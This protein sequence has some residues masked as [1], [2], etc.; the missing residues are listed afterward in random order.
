MVDK[1]SKSYDVTGMSC[2][3]C[4]ARV[5]KAVSAI[6]GVVSC[7]VNLLTNSMTVDGSADENA[8]IDAVVRAGYGASLKA[9]P[10]DLSS[11][12]YNNEEK[13]RIDPIFTRLISSVFLL[14]ILM[15]LSMGHMLSLPLPNFIES[16]PI[17]NVALQLILSATVMA[18]N[19][20]FFVNGTKG[21]I[22]RAPNMDTLVSLGSAAAFIY[23]TAQ[24]CRMIN[25]SSGLLHSLYFESA[26]MIPT[27]ITVGKLL[28]SR[29]KGKTTSALKGL[30]DLSPKTATVI[31]DGKEVRIKAEE[32]NAGDIFAVRPGESFPADGVVIKGESAVN[33]SMLTG[34]SIPV[35]K[36]EGDEVSGAT[37]N[38]SGY[39]ECRATK[40]GSDTILSK[41]IKTV[42]DAAAT[43]APIARTA[44][45]VAGVFVPAVMAIA[46]VTAAT[47]FILGE[48]VGVAL[49]RAISVLVISCPCALGLAT[50]VAIMVGSGVGAKNGILFKT[51][52]ALEITGKAK[53]VVLDKTGTITA[54]EPTVYEILPCSVSENELLTLAA[55]AES[56]S[57]HPLAKSIM[58]EAEKR[59]LDF[60]A[61]EEFKA[62]SGM[63]VSCTLENQIL[64]GGKYDFI[65]EIATIPS[66]ISQKAAA[67]TDRGCTPL[68][69]ARNNDFLGLIAV[70][71][72][73]K[74]DSAEAV[75]EMKKMGLNVVI[76]TGDNP[77]TA[78][79]IADKAGITDVIASVMPDAKASEVKRLKK[80]GFTV[81]IGDGINDAPALTEADVGI[82][83]GAGSDIAIDAADAVIIGGSL[84]DAVKAIR[85]SR[86]TL[87]NVK[88]NLFWAF[89]YNILGIPLA[90]GVFI[91]MTGWQLSPMICAAAMSLSSFF[92][93]CNALRLGLI[94]LKGEFNIPNEK[95][96]II[97]EKTF[98][99][100]GMMCPHCEAHV[101]KAVESIKNVTEAIA[102]HKE[103]TVTVKMSKEVANKYIISAITDAGYKVLS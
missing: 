66:D 27:L 72:P 32:L 19:H 54:G 80:K 28:E 81:M 1:R 82:A 25:G 73:I 53:N 20:R 103:G 65:K 30:M 39:L 91:P 64:Y 70:S 84:K 4:S 37:V 15:Y 33:E 87:K 23:S 46:A 16:R 59:G 68:Y 99:V 24:L 79:A 93:V 36:K 90:A 98:K 45:K 97:M 101:K 18:V 21:I 50:P 41:I 61:P 31:R 34:E 35:D 86:A 26:A 3:A 29:A 40:V 63:G 78:K 47:W 51:A 55:S 74:E 49:S 12:I 44:D 13:N 94:K 58:G 89:F 69:F 85:L 38:Q 10:G 76:L 60:P 43:K 92:V 57:E 42:S 100:E 62:L 56:R 83:I 71:D 6:D 17:L 102:S 9:D 2:A 48:N 75:A 5:E 88:E 67:L 95:E 8:V 7:S 96:E 14:V 77:R 52:T 11:H 22:H